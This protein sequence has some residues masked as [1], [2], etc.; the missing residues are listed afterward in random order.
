MKKIYENVIMNRERNANVFGFSSK[1]IDRIIPM[2]FHNEAELIYCLRGKLKIWIDGQVTI[3]NAEDVYFINNN[4]PHATQS[5]TN[6]EVIVLQLSGEFFEK[7]KLFIQLNSRKPVSSESVFFEI[8]ELV[9]EVFALHYSEERFAY[10]LEQ[11]KILNLEF[12]LAN[13]FHTDV[14]NTNRLALNR[15]KKVKKVIDIIKAHYIENISLNEVAR[16][17]GY[18]ES[19]LSRMFRQNV[20]QT[21]SE[22]KQ[23]LCLEKAIDLMEKTDLNFAEIAFESGFP[24]EKSFRSVFKEV[25]KKTPREYKKGQKMT[26]LM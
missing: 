16:L 17:S 18:S 22:F 20:G 5:I 23:A 6:N 13:Y 3:L 1:D 10:L 26:E 25:M 2:H 11:S 19:Y 8:K 9:R 4:V 24:N 12:L 14:D 21:F 15:Q 7:E